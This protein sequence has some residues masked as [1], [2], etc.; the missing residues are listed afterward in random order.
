M[1]IVLFLIILNCITLG[2]DIASDDKD[3][4]IDGWMRAFFI[5][6]CVMVLVSEV[7]SEV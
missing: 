6:I 4:K 7:Q 5:A 2:I 3:D 1:I